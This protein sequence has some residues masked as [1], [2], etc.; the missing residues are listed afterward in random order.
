[1]QARTIINFTRETY[2]LC[3]FVSFPNIR[4]IWFWQHAVRQERRMHC[5]LSVYGQH[6]QLSSDVGLHVRL[7]APPD[8]IAG[9][10][11]ASSALWQ[12]ISL[13]LK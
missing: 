1:M 6:V 13:R 4:G 10:A 3:L 5:L 8:K 12:L 7:Q 2:N 11:L 9:M